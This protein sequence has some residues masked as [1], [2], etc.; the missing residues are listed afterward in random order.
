MANKKIKRRLSSSE[1]F[2]VMKSIFDKV[3]WLGIIFLG[4]GLYNLL[5]AYGGLYYIL[6]GGIILLGLC[7]FIIREFEHLR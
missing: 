3:L 2:E 4:V 1:E 6:A 7:W 5:G